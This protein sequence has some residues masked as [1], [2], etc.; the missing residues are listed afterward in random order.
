MHGAPFCQPAK[1]NG[2]KIPVF[3]FTFSVTELHGPQVKCASS[4]YSGPTVAILAQTFLNAVL[5]VDT[6]LNLDGELGG[7]VCASWRPEKEP[8]QPNCSRDAPVLLG[9]T[10]KTQCN[11]FFCWL[12]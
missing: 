3:I 11:V 10:E 6:C 1:Q 8:I 12:I 4:L 5:T 7:G 9:N 2:L